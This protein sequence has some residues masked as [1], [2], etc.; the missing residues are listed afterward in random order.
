[1]YKTTQKPVPRPE[2][3][4]EQESSD[5]DNYDEQ[6]P[7]LVSR[8]WKHPGGCNRI[9]AMPK[10]PN[11][12]ATWS[13]R[14]EVHVWD[15][16][17]HLKLLDMNSNFKPAAKSIYVCKKHTVEGFALAWNNQAA[18][19]LVTGDCNSKIYVWNPKEG[20]GW[21]V[22]LTPFVG[23]SDSVEDLHW[24]PSEN[25]VFTSCSIDK[26]I[27]IWDLREPSQKSVLK[28]PNAHTSDVNVLDWNP[29][30]SHLLASGGDDALVKVWDL[31]TMKPCDTKEF[32]TESISSVRWHPHESSVL[33]VASDDDITSIWDLS[34]EADETRETEGAEITNEMEIPTQLAFVH[35]GQSYVKEL[36]WHRQIPSLLMSTAQ[37]GFNIF[38]PSNFA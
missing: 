5:S 35:R 13:D 24:S 8:S 38:K 16:E 32:H 17:E 11:I 7:M 28:V 10:K 18:G 1:L 6:Q 29:I 26:S 34:W 19:R 9:R 3:G 20:G 23:H 37:D 14:G 15:G 12:I 22:G 27:R 25:T 36:H 21:E 31:R 33:A 2:D 30:D 4:D